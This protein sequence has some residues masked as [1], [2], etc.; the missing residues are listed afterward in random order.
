MYVRVRYL[1][2]RNTTQKKGSNGGTVELSRSLSNLR[3]LYLP[4]NFKVSSALCIRVFQAQL[5][6]HLHK[7]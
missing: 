3:D 6:Q 2:E 4:P 1:A 7:A 5:T